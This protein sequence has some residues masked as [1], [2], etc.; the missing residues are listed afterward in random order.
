[1]TSIFK[2]GLLSTSILV[3]AVAVATPAF[4]Q[5]V[6]EEQA[7]ATNQGTIV[8]TGSRISNPNLE[9]SSPVLSIGSDEFDYQQSVSAEELLREIPGAVPSIGPGVNNGANGSATLNLRGLGSNRNIILMDGQRIV[10]ATLGGVTDLNII[11]VALIERV[12][13]FT[14]GASTV[15]GADAI[16]G[17]VNFITKND[18]AGI[19]AFAGF[20]VAEQG[21]GQ[22]FRTDLTI[23]ANFDDGRGNAVLSVGYADTDPVLQGNRAIGRES[24][25]SVTGLPQGSA[26]ATPASILFPFTGSVNADGTGFD[27]G[28]LTNFNFNPLNVFQTPLERF[29]VFGKARYEVTDNIEL[30]T[31]ALYTKNT[32]RQIIAPSGS[33]FSALSVPLS[34]PFLTQS[35]RNQLCTSSGITAAECAVAS[36]AAPGQAGYREINTQ[37]GRRFTEAGP[38]LTTFTT[39]TFQ[40]TAGVR[41]QITD[42][43]G[44][45]LN[46]TYGESSRVNTAL[47]QGSRDRLQQALRAQSTDACNVNTGG[48]VPFDLFGIEGSITPEMFNFINVPT[49]AFTDT[50]LANVQGTISGD[51][52][53]TSPFAN[54]PIGIA[55]GGEYRKYSGSSFGDGISSQPGAVLGAGAAALPISGSYDSYEVFGEINIPL[56]QDRPF[57]HL[58]SVEGGVRYSDYSTSGG[59]WTYKAGATWAP[60]EDIRFRGVF[61]RAVRAPNLAELFQPEVVQLSN[62]SVDPCQGTL[63]QIAARGV[64]AAVCA[65]SL[66]QSG[67]PAAA[68][69]SIP[70]PVAGQI[71]TTFTGNPLL[72]PERANTLTVGAVIE[73]RFLPGFTMTV[74]YYDIDI[75]RAISSPSQADVI[76]TCYFNNTNAAEPA[77]L[78]IL[79]NPLTG[80]LSGP[81]DTTFGPFLGL[82]NRGAIE[83]NGIDLSLN[84]R[85]DLDFAILNLNF[86]GNWTNTS[87][88]QATEISVNRECVGF[89]SVA[90]ASLQPEFSWNLRTTLSFEAVD[91]SFLWRHIDG[92]EVEPLQNTTPTS[93]F[94][95]YETIPAYDYFDLSMRFAITDNLRVTATVSNLFDKNPPDVGNTIGSTSF[96]SGNTFPSTYDAIGRRFNVGATMRF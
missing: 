17:V 70:A 87:K 13:V 20:G 59:N 69:G 22:T 39:Q 74:D 67:S 61:S 23:G 65:A 28:T 62:R 76:D 94:D 57:F 77:C 5:E 44:F 49:F 47:N 78:A 32:V 84:Y 36:T 58:L 33:F 63:A 68:L 2:T 64:S 89:Y 50:A 81:N 11:P 71:N 54:E 41:G 52:G 10:P 31:S 73:P 29:S 90:C 75:T 14:G 30:Y 35:M 56:V 40:V 79:R 91:V 55:V 45:D 80:G 96:N 46:G 8:V 1:M 53:V 48:C 92:M 83:T 37:I 19:E 6:Q 27:V 9:Q 93:T 26:T 95:A 86:N 7:A 66:A 3:G 42:S 72:D 16:A 85:T 38:R 21:D 4:A 25:S 15:Y 60:I 88:F 34:N 43:L 18:F 12:E 82:S 24:R 51:F